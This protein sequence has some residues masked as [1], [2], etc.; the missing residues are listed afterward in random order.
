MP[1]YAPSNQVLSIFHWQLQTQLV[2]RCKVQQLLQFCGLGTF[3][4]SFGTKGNST[5]GLQIMAMPLRNVKSTG[6][7][8]C[9]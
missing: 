3:S 6:A 5:T 4:T 7:D 1:R 9:I 2:K 8:P